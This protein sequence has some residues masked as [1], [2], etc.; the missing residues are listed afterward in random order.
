RS[1][2]MPAP[3]GSNSGTWDRLAERPVDRLAEPTAPPSRRERTGRSEQL[4]L[5]PTPPA[6]QRQ[7]RAER[8]NGAPTRRRAVRPPTEQQ[9]PVNGIG[10]RLNTEP[11]SPA[12]PMGSTSL[13]SLTPVAQPPNPLSVAAQQPPPPAPPTMGRP[14]QA[15]P[16]P[17]AVEPRQQQPVEPRPQPEEPRTGPE[18]RE[19]MDP[20]CLTTE[21][22]PISAEVQKKRVVD[23]TL[24]R[25]SAVHAEMAA[26]EKQRRTR[27][28]KIM[29][30][31]NRDADLEDALSEAAASGPKAAGSR[32]SG[33]PRTMKA[34]P[35]EQPAEVEHDP[36]DEDAELAE[37]DMV[38]P[39][40]KQ[41]G[42][43][44]GRNMPARIR[45]LPPKGPTGGGSGLRPKNPKN[46]QPSTKTQSRRRMV[47]M[48]KIVA[49]AGTLLILA[50]TFVGWHDR[51]Q[52][53]DQVQ[54]VAAL[55]VNSPAIQG[56][57]KQ[58]G[59]ENFLMVG[60]STANGAPTPSL[61]T[62]LV[63]HI[64]ADRSRAVIVSF[65]PDLSVNRPACAKWNN[66]SSSYTGAPGP[67]QDGV[68]LNDVYQFGGPKCMTD[69]VQDVSGLRINHFVGIDAQGFQSIV[70]GLSGV[71]VCTKAP[72]KDATLG[73]IVSQSGQTP[74][75]GQQALN[76]VQATH[77][78][79][80][81]VGDE[82]EI[83]RQQ[84]FLA[85]ALRAGVNQS[86]LLSASKLDG[87]LNV[88]TKSTFGDNMGADQLYDLAQSLQGIDLG[89]VTF[90]SLPTT[91]ALDST[92]RETLVASSAGQLF[93]T[94]INNSAL[95]GESSGSSATNTTGSNS[96]FVDPKTIKI[97]VDNAGNPTNGIAAGTKTKLANQGFDVVSSGTDTHQDKT[98][99]RYSADLQAAAQTLGTSVPQATLQVDPSL[100]GAI[101]LDVA[102][103]FD[104]VVTA[105]H[106]SSA[107]PPAQDAGGGLSTVNAANAPCL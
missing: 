10:S 82:G 78:A 2:P 40:L 8:Q 28:A 67:T 64:P 35:V 72:L 21:M 54:Q 26:E 76:F 7:P 73:T 56:G 96:V 17:P 92:G 33:Q 6:R 100:R 20:L 15:D 57:T 42:L 91:G 69:M 34:P 49:V 11:E 66:A 14:P 63:A 4:D 22:E 93:S 65:P 97:Q 46:P 60:T 31:L 29:P 107:T 98:V 50:L 104:N 18:P 23:A 41:R 24:V 47:L 95:V 30:W 68:S 80:D 61:S 58:N 5:P 13:T 55:D 90:A 44:T 37:L 81:P 89:R 9:P 53:N 88:F 103:G 99:I 1:G 38:E 59:D 106:P 75:S 105:P 83:H 27:R 74:L 77:V 79:G 94:I 84:L 3:R 19:E 85:A 70:G 62:V 12:P 25:F 71:T 39:P 87:F 43:S 36:V 52:V 48:A 86:V 101:I 16:R 102:A 32:P 51:T 45:E